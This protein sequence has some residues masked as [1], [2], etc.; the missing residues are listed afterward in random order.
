MFK[1]LKKEKKYEE[2]MKKRKMCGNTIVETKNNTVSAG[3]VK[4]FSL[5]GDII[6]SSADIRPSDPIRSCDIHQLAA[7]SSC[8]P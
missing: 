4:L 2:K 7:F 6:T 8:A 5:N 3:S 1:A